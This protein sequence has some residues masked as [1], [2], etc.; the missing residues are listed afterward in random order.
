MKGLISK[1]FLP[2]IN[3]NKL[4]RY[5][6]YLIVSLIFQNILFTKLR[7]LEVWPM[8]LP[9]VAVAM[10][11]FEGATWG[12]LF[13]LVLGIF[14]DMGFVENTVYFTIVLP[15]LSFAAAFIANFFINRRFFAYMGAA[16]LGL[17]IAAAGQ[18]LKTAASDSF[19]M[20]MVTTAV[21]QTVWS[22][23]FAALAY[24][25]PARISRADFT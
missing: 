22:L 13:S 11:M 15:G 1:E 7:I 24:L 9:A 12:P 2:K 19:S 5:G 21:L 8:V 25:P 14:A 16:L 17:S 18:L 10:G 23:P 3:L 20:I 6:A 4:I